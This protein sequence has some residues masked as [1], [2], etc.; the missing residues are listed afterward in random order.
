MLR[1]L[2]HVTKAHTDR[3]K[4]VDCNKC[5]VCDSVDTQKQEIEKRKRR[6]LLA[7]LQLNSTL[8]RYNDDYY[9]RVK[10]EV[11]EYC[12]SHASEEIDPPNFFFLL[13]PRLKDLLLVV[14][15]PAVG[16]DCTDTIH[17]V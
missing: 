2:K 14:I 16:L 3:Q 8:V 15:L 6:E 9:V 1:H 10:T 13:C 12:Q 4:L 11:V 17:H 7:C 5:V